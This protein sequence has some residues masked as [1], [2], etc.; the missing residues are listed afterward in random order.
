VEEV[1]SNDS[2]FEG[3]VGS[4]KL[5]GGYAANIGGWGGGGS[6]KAGIWGMV[7]TEGSIGLLCG[8]S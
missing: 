4:G 6:A 2:P 3:G 7:E 8:V 5:A 1:W